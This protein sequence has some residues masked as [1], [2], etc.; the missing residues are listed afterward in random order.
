MVKIKVKDEFSPLRVVIA[1]EGAECHRHVNRRLPQLRR[2]GDLKSCPIFRPRVIE[3]QAAFLRLLKF[4]GVEVESP[5]TQ[6]E[7]FCQIFTRYPCFAVS[8]KLSDE[9]RQVLNRRFFP[10]RVRPG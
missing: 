1:H 4:S 8:D 6:P 3:Q 9:G 5:K 7:A 10:H 2:A